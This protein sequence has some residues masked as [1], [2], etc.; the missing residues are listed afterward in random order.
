MGTTAN[1]LFEEWPE[2]QNP[3]KEVK[4]HQVQVD[5]PGSWWTEH[6]SVQHSPVCAGKCGEWGDDNKNWKGTTLCLCIRCQRVLI[7]T[8]LFMAGHQAK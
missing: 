2:S 1:F 5:S 4:R 7:V 6:I 3:K 8:G